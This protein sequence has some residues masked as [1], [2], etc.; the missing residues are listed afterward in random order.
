MVYE[1]SRYYNNLKGKE[2]IPLNILKK[3]PSAELRPNQKD[4]DSLPD[5]EILDE[6]LELYI[7]KCYNKDDIIKKGFDKK[8]VEK[9]IK[10]VKTNEYKR[11][12]AALGLKVTSKAFG[13]GRRMPITN[14]WVQ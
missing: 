12:Q 1:L 14:R 5:Y 13:S 10:L 7:E 4:S 9:V 3:E 8:T 6:I 11:H 2:I